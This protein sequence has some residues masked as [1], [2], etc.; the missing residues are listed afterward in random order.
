VCVRACVIQMNTL[1]MFVFPHYNLEFES[2]VRR[3]VFFLQFFGGLV[4]WK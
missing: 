3:V 2:V 1:R 4:N